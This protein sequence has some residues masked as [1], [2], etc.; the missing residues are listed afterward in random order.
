MTVVR[1]VYDIS[2]QATAMYYMC[3][4]TMLEE[5]TLAHFGFHC[6]VPPYDQN[7]MDTYGGWELGYSDYRDQDIGAYDCALLNFCP[8]QLQFNESS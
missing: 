5:P 3:W 4:Y 2:L 7:E 1:A 6:H 8:G